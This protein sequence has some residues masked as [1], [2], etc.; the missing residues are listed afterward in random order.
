MA[1]QGH[2]QADTSQTR[3]PWKAVVH[4][5]HMRTSSHMNYCVTIIKPFHCVIA[6]IVL[7]I[8]ACPARGEDPSAAIADYHKKVK[9]ILQRYCFDCHGNGS[10]EGGV[11]FDTFSTDREILERKNLWL[12]V[13]DNVRAGLMPPPKD[14]DADFRPTAEEQRQLVNWIKSGAFAIDP[15]NPDPGHVVPRRLNRIE[16][17]NT[18]RDLVGYKFKADT[19]FPPDD[20]GGGFDNNGD[21]LTIST[22]LLEKYLIAAEHIVDQ[23]VPKSRELPEYKDGDKREKENK[24]DKRTEADRKKKEQAKRAEAMAKVEEKYRRFFPDG[25][26]PEESNKRDEYAEAIL[27]RFAT[28]A[29]RRPVEQEKVA[30]LSKLAHSVYSQ[31]DATFEQGVG[32]AMMAVLASPHFLFRVEA[33]QPKSSEPFALLD[34]Y[35]LASR[36]SYFL[37]STMPDQELFDLADRGQLRSQLSDQ[38]KRMLQDSKIESGLVRNFTGQWLRTRDVYSVDINGKAVLGKGPVFGNR[39]TKYD[40]DGKIRDA[41]RQETE[42]YFAYVLEEDRS[43]LEF[44]DSDYAFLNERLAKQYDIPDVKGDKFR[45]VKLPSDSFRGGVLTQGSVLAVTSNPTRTSPVKRGVFILENILG[46]PPP[47]PPPNVADLETALEDAEG[48]KPMLS[49]VLALHRDS[50][51]CSSCHDRMDPI[52][53]AFE[54]FIPMGNWRDKEAGRT[55]DASGSL[56]TGEHFQDVRE[57]KRVLA[58]DR[59]LDFYRCLTKKMLTYAVGRG[60]D[61]RDTVTVDSIVERLVQDDGRISSLIMAIV[62]SPAFQK[63]GTQLPAVSAQ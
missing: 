59:R 60:L 15:K 42:R 41:M 52:G 30:Q 36:L 38:V 25:P 61:Y 53:L 8:F 27:R 13:L 50:A 39:K 29:F 31:P 22:L 23:A 14:V 43:V 6:A 63:Q 21:V 33:P 7:C 56:I 12:A 34:E 40:F 3:R 18:I 5:L 62:E 44:I 17:Q 49:E 20:T 57:L 28:Q 16:Y 24:D 26:P 9:P 58:T 51:V 19:E 4:S 47:P 11:S 10:D 35:A 2:Q 32:R 1:F 55:I 45:R 48:E 46:T 54:N 37:W